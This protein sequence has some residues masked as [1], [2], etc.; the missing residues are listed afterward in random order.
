MKEI[1]VKRSNQTDTYVKTELDLEI[2]RELLEQSET[3]VLND[4]SKK[5][6]AKW[7][8][9][10]IILALIIALARLTMHIFF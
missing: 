4:T 5:H 1:K 10:G 9:A 3:E 7:I 2:E 6:S 8:Y